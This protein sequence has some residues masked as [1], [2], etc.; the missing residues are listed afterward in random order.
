MGRVETNPPPIFPLFGA[1]LRTT[2]KSPLTWSLA[3]SSTEVDRSASAIYEVTVG[4]LRQSSSHAAVVFTSDFF[5]LQEHLDT[6]Q[7]VSTAVRFAPNSGGRT[8]VAYPLPF[9][10]LNAEALVTIWVRGHRICGGI[11]NVNLIRPQDL[12]ARGRKGDHLPTSVHEIVIGAIEG[13]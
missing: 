12:S 7:H 8:N 9:C 13:V 1:T 3:G 4:S 2:S 11:R 5:L 6:H 10:L